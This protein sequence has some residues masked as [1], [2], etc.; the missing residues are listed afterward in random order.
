MK[1]RKTNKKSYKN[2]K[3]NKNRKWIKSGG[4]QNAN[5]NKKRDYFLQYIHDPEIPRLLVSL[6]EKPPI[7]EEK[8]NSWENFMFYINNI[9]ID[10]N[11][12]NNKLIYQDYNN[13]NYN[14]NYKNLDTERIF[15]E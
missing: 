14:I 3:T 5:I 10:T 15:K 13:L 7:P 12:I 8:N 4:S 6:H 2:K 9:L 11:G 1:N